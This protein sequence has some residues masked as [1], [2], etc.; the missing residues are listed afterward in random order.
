MWVLM[1]AKNLQFRGNCSHL[2]EFACI[3]IKSQIKLTCNITLF[4]FLNEIPC[5]LLPLDHNTQPNIINKN[6]PP[7]TEVTNPFRISTQALPNPKSIDEMGSLIKDLYP[8][9][10][11]PVLLG[12]VKYHEKH[13]CNSTWKQECQG[14]GGSDQGD[15]AVCKE[16]Q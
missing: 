12:K 7:K 5:S 13:Q 2:Q 8:P 11:I 16:S 10:I 15:A 3:I 6:V 4:F 1:P 9:Y 14:H